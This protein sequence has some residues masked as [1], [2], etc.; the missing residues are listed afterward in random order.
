M[1][2]I[3]FFTAH[4]FFSEDETSPQLFFFLL[5]PPCISKSVRFHAIFLWVFLMAQYFPGVPELLKP[6]F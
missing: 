2:A 1:R 4:S 3:M 6:K 5:P